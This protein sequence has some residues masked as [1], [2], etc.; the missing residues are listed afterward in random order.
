VKATVLIADDDAGVRF[1]L[2][3]LLEDEGLGVVEAGDG[4][5]ALRQL[6]QGGID[7]VFT[8]LRMPKVDGLALLQRL[9]ALPS[10]RP[11][12]VLMTAHGSER[13]AVE[14]MKLGALDYFRKPFE[15]E[16]VLQVV[17]GALGAA[18]VGAV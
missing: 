12:V 7:L 16:E 4:E 15:L 1:T 11:E 18:R 8:D 3:G 14:A 9:Q 2:R 17:G 5:E 6:E 13:H 10:P